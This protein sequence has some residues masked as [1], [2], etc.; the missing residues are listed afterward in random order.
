[1][2]EIEEAKMLID[3]Y[4]TTFLFTNKKSEAKQIA[5]M[6]IDARIEELTILPNA[7]QYLDRIN[8]LQGIKKEI[9]NL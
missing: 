2:T 5:L 8:F 6:T 7:M 4:F 3:K 1:M 9:N